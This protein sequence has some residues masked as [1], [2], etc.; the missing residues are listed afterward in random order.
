MEWSEH[1]VDRAKG[2]LY[3]LGLDDAAIESALLEPIGTKKDEWDPGYPGERIRRWSMVQA[4][5]TKWHRLRFVFRI[6]RERTPQQP[7]SISVV[8]VIDEGTSS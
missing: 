4:L 7:G 6:L 5:T 1:G 8:T 2:R 3:S